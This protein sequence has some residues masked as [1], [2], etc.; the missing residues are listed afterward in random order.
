[1]FFKLMMKIIKF[2]AF[3]LAACL[4]LPLSASALGQMSEPID[5]KDAMRGQQIN[6][7]I[8]VINNEDKKIAVEFTASGQIE[9][10]VKF[11]KP[12]DLKNQVSTTSAEVGK[13]LNMI[14][15][16]SIPNDIP[17]GEYTGYV[18]VSNL[19]DLY[20]DKNQSGASLTQK[21]DRQ[22]TIKIS[23][24]ENVKLEVSV[25]PE[26][27]DIGLNQ[28]LKVRVIYDNQSNISLTPSVSFKI[29]TADEEGKTVYNVIYPYPEGVAAVNSRGYFEIPAL[30]IPTT[31]IAKGKY[32]AQLQFIRG[33]K[34]LID[35][36][37]SFSVGAPSSAFASKIGAIFGGN[38]IWLFGLLALILLGIA[39]WLYKKNSNLKQSLKIKFKN[40]KKKFAR[41]VKTAKSGIAGMF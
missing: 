20:V 17:N 10:W 8:I 12:G 1:M 19:P 9:G 15:V 24:T 27:Y 32:L 5:I 35:K 30:E 23:D 41:T 14:A 36:Q 3:I 13:N 39:G 2:F 18:S 16:F 6:Q 22:V 33:D 37:F 31:G 38:S 25:I 28:P 29:K 40:L 4:V 26:T 21:I 7:E 34:S 11:Y